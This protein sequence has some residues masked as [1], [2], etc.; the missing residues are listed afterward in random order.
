MSMS[1]RA[2][3]SHAEAIRLCREYSM[4]KFDEAQNNDYYVY[5]MQ[6][7][8]DDDPMYIWVDLSS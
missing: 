6:P 5:G 7:F 2:Y 8:D 4:G 1:T 3:I